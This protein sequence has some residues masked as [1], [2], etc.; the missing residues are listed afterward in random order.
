MSHLLTV[1]TLD[2]S[3]EAVRDLKA[4]MLTS[5]ALRDAVQTDPSLYPKYSVLGQLTSIAGESYGAG[6]TYDGRTTGHVLKFLTPPQRERLVASCIAT[7]FLRDSVGG[8][9]TG[10]AYLTEEQ[11]DRLI[12]TAVAVG[13]HLINPTIK[14][15][16][17]KGLCAGMAHWNQA[18]RDRLFQAALEIPRASDQANA[19]AALGEVMV[20]FDANQRVEL[21]IRA[22]NFPEATQKAAAM[23]GVGRGLAHLRPYEISENQ[24]DRLVYEIFS[25]EENEKFEAMYGLCRGLQPF[26][27]DHRNRLFEETMG[28]TAL[29][30]EQAMANLGA[31]MA[32]LTPEQRNTLV[33][34]AIHESTTG[35]A[36]AGL[37][38]GWASLTAVQRN[39]ILEKATGISTRS[40]D[41]LLIERLGGVLDHLSIEERNRLIEEVST[42]P[43]GM[44]KAS[45][46]AGLCKGLMYMSKTQS[47]LLIRAAEDLGTAANRATARAGMFAGAAEMVA[48]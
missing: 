36:I 31:S 13:G 7:H 2:T 27:V 44:D 5:R 42:L 10:V 18:Q 34:V 17:I 4:A 14:A 35:L 20:Y 9:G 25:L 38:E 48:F 41:A 19:I 29:Y 6:Q 37:I 1:D 45:A 32:Y 3:R 15:A 47:D 11:R 21:V 12:D 46:I 26:D 22:R 43:D 24:L 28:C 30:K 40:M 16:A 33:D 23:A 8:L 39:R